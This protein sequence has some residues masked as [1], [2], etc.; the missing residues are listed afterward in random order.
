M[1]GDFFQILTLLIKLKESNLYRNTHSYA[2]TESVNY[3][4]PVTNLEINVYK[5]Q[6][7][8]TVEMKLKGKY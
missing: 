4:H 6:Y 5:L 7:Y 8:N 2:P 1:S 3:Q